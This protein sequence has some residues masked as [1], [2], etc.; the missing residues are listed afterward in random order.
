MPDRREILLVDDDKDVLDLLSDLLTESSYAVRRATSGERALASVEKSR[1]DL[2]IMDV[3]LPDQDG[4]S[5]LRTLKR[6]HPELEV[7]VMTA[8]G[9]SS[10]A[11]QAIGDGAY[12]YVTKPFET[13]DLLATLRRV[14]ERTEMAEVVANLS[15]ELGKSAAKRERIVGSSKPMLEVYKV[16]GKVAA[17]HATVMIS[18][19]S[20]TGKE[21]VAEA[22]HRASPRNAFPLVKVSCA[23]LPETLLETE[24]FGHER[25]SFTGAVAMRKGRFELANKGTIFL[26]EIGDMTL[27]TQTKLLRILQERE[28]E[29]IGSNTSIKVDIRVIAATNRDLAEEVDR[30]RFREDLYYRLNV[31]HIHMPTLRE[32]KDDIPALVEHFLTK[33]RSSQDA[34]PSTITEQALAQLVAY[35]W[36]GNVREL[37]NAVERAVV[38]SRGDP[39]TLEHLPFAEPAAKGARRAS[40]TKAGKADKAGE[41]PTTTA[42]ARATATP[43]AGGGNGSSAPGAEA[44]GPDEGAVVVGAPSPFKRQVADLERRL[45]LEALERAG[46]NRTRAAEELGI[47]RRLLYDKMRE[48]GLGE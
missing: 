20:G 5:V 21:L 40:G 42:T 14:F 18:G 2:V 16:I 17:S 34:P 4:V 23:A 37:E 47:Y 46:G 24:L 26:D 3:Q 43:P 28:F 45:I 36:P 13:D 10:T 11:I 41:A 25:G 39:I 8:F 7:I 12:D 33:Y 31:I 48:F 6:L 19:E 44:P 1:P 29:R 15:L 32:R 22:I 38:L 30:S 35:D 9:G 27:G